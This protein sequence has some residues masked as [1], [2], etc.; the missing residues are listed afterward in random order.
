MP[1]TITLDR[2]EGCKTPLCTGTLEKLEDKLRQ[3]LINECFDDFT[4]EDSYTGNELS[5]YIEEEGDHKRKER[6]ADEAPITIYWR[7]EQDE[8]LYSEGMRDFDAAEWKRDK[9][10]KAGYT[11]IQIIVKGKK[12]GVAR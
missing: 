4:I 10:I 12:K 11:D 2:F 8:K 3:F 9:L 1:I 7:K 5:S 6:E